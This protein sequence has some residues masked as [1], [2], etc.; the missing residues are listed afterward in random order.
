MLSKLDKLK[1]RK[2]VL[3]AD[4]SLMAVWGMAGWYFKQEEK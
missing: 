2:E 1:G 3:N 4:Q